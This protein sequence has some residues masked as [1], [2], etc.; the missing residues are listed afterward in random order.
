MRLAT[1]G[2]LQSLASSS[3]ERR[4]GLAPSGNFSGPRCDT[5]PLC[6]S[7]TPQALPG[8]RFLAL[9]HVPGS[10]QVFAA[11]LVGLLADLAAALATALGA[12]GC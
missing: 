2:G 6:G 1:E 4:C 9:A 8:A 5:L 10:A 7:S 3:H 11:E 12:L